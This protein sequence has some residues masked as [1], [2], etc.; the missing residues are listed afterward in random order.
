PEDGTF[1]FF[2]NP[3]RVAFRNFGA[4]SQGLPKRNPGLKLANA[5]SVSDTRIFPGTLLRRVGAFFNEL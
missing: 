4:L 1:L 2:R 3:E 5:F